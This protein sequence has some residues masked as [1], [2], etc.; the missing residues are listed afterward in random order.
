ME[1]QTSTNGSTPRAADDFDVT[2]LGAGIAGS[3]LA[4]ILAKQGVRTLLID[5]VSHPRFA[6]GE[7]TIPQTLVN[8]RILAARYG[9]PEIKT[10]STLK[11]CARHI[12][13]TFGRKAHFG[14]MI[15]HEGEPQDASECTLFNAPKLLAE[16]HHLFRQDTDSYMF[17]TAIR[18][19][20]VARQNMRIEDIEFDDSGVTLGATDGTTYRTRYVV[21]ASGIRSP[22]AEKLGVRETPTRFKHHAR[23]LWTHMQGVTPT[24]DLF[25]RSKKDTP[26]KE[27]YAGTVHHMFE[28]GWFWVIGF[29][30]TELSKSSLCSVGLTLDERLY[31]RDPDQDP[32]E[33]FFEMAARYPD[34]E[35]QYRGAVPVREWTS[36]DRIQWSSTQTVGDRWCLLGHA[37]GF[38]DPLFSFGLANTTNAMLALVPR[39]LKAIREDDDLSAERFEYVDRVQ[40][41]EL[42]Y[43]DRVV[44]AAY[45][46]FT[47]QDLWSAV[48][49]IWVWGT[50]A[51]TFRSRE[52]LT[53]Y[54]EDGDESVFDALEDGPHLGLPWPDHD[55]YAALFYEMDRRLDAVQAGEESA[56]AAADALFDRLQASNFVPHPFGFSDRTVRFINPTPK[57][58]AKTARWA[59]RDADPVVRRLMIGNGREAIKLAARGDRIF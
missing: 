53:K 2:I 43:N 39:L 48:F 41:K 55:G 30:N 32:G 4:A 49:R 44:N 8:L 10:L 6:I 56:S 46:A 26:P 14:F 16:A 36:T 20:A 52:A 3:M 57:M 38:I 1:S 37:A 21:D 18:Y 31:P 23:S 17:Y 50:N 28:R 9:V 25:P 54:F 35:R 42:D 59:F 33:E 5:A 51:G 47:H 22:L 13:P 19:G 27:W 40:Q 58:L 34:I 24:D 29:D 12:G 15:H 45:T 11:D 7:S